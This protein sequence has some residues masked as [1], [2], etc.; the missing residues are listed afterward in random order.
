MADTPL[1]PNLSPDDL[2]KLVAATVAETLKGLNVGQQDQTALGQTIGE[3]VAAGIAKT[4]RQKVTIGEYLARPHSQIRP[5]AASMAVTLSRPTYDNGFPLLNN[6]LTAEETTLLNSLSHS[7]RYLDR[8]VE[9]IVA[10]EG[11]ESE[12]HL[13]YPNATSDQRQ[14]LA[15][16][17]SFDPKRHR[18]PFQAMLESVAAEQAL[19]RENEALEAEMREQ[20]KAK[21]K[22]RL[23]KPAF[24]MTKAVREAREAAAARE[25]DV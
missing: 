17:Y 5:T 10:I 19:E 7:G 9:V 25:A 2:V 13:R 12:L 20:V 8:Y 1:I 6:S 21:A 16:K 15:T 23:A 14:N 24:T 18:T 4:Q 3:S 11:A 22:E